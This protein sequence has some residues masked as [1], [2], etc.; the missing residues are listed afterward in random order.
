MK[1]SIKYLLSGIF[2]MLFLGL[3][4]AWSVF[5]DPI[6]QTLGC[7]QAEISSVYTLFLA[8][9]CLGA[10]F[11]GWFRGGARPKQA[12]A[13]S[14]LLV[15]GG[16]G[17]SSL[18]ASVGLLYLSYGVLYGLGVGLG[19]NTVISAVVPCFPGHSGLTGGLLFM[20][21]GL[22]A[23]VFAVPLSSLIYR[24]GWAMTF[25]LLALLC[26]L[27]ISV[28]I[29]VLVPAP[30]TRSAAA[31]VSDGLT[32]R[33]M[34]KTRQFYFYFIWVTMILAGGMI[35]IS[36]GAPMALRLGLTPAAAALGTSVFSVF[37]AASRLIMGT[38]YDRKG[39]TLSMGVL[40]G[41][42][43]L[44]TGCL[45]FAQTAGNGA[46]LFAGLSLTGFSYGGVPSISSPFTLDYFGSRNFAQNFSIMGFYTLFGSFF[47]PF[48]FGHLYEGT[49]SYPASYLLLAAFAAVSACMLLLHCRTNRPI[50]DR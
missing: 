4:L 48:L 7:S 49:G 47:G 21:V 11:C 3:Y 29:F 34:L 39:A 25:R 46:A 35:V 24:I 9:F 27:A 36:D 38:L 40:L 50:T 44:G 23:M 5:V 41:V 16:L 15:C 22:S 17:L 8:C 12:L 32:A 6:Q 18:A 26:L 1:S 45:L 20:G 30:E 14:A 28:S 42:F 10:L 43:A 33:E 19:Y 13:L 31:N 37:N 2:S